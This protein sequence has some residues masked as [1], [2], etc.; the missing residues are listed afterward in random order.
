MG[1]FSLIGCSADSWIIGWLEPRIKDHQALNIPGFNEESESS[2]PSLALL[3]LQNRPKA[4]IGWPCSH[5][6]HALMLRI[7]SFI[8]SI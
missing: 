7:R 6:E 2:L 4:L 5:Q 1:L 8:C 3:S